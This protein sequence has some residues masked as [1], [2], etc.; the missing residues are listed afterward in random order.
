MGG[1]GLGEFSYCHRCESVASNPA[2][3][4]QRSDGDVRTRE[5]IGQ[6]NSLKRKI[7]NTA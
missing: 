5:V 2:R 7:Y 6:E 1:E 3:T 4:V